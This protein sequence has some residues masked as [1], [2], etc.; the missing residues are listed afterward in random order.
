MNAAGFSPAM[1]KYPFGWVIA[2]K[3]THEISASIIP[4][5]VRM[6]KMVALED[7]NLISP[8]SR[9]R[10]NPLSGGNYLSADTLFSFQLFYRAEFAEL[11][12]AL[13]EENKG[14]EPSSFRMARFSRPLERHCS[15]FS[16]NT[17]SRLE[18]HQLSVGKSASFE[19]PQ[20]AR[21]IEST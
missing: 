17:R 6:I 13:K 4:P 15:L 16:L 9:A 11:N 5:H 7:S 21:S 19:L 1:Q 10:I 8:E 12:S 3:P 2:W 20:I 18:L 14:I